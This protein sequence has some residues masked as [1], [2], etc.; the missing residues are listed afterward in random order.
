MK[1]ARKMVLLSFSDSKN[2]FKI[3]NIN[4]FEGIVYHC[5]IVIAIRI[6]IEF[7]LIKPYN[8]TMERMKVKQN[9]Y[10]KLYKISLMTHNT[11]LIPQYTL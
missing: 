1:H 11:N 10:G 7:V 6:L 8:F 3:I 4:I 5:V 2:Q 9:Q